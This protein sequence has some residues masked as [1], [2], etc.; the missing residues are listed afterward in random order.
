MLQIIV[1][2]VLW[3]NV[4]H[5]N[6]DNNDSALV[7]EEFDTHANILSTL[8]LLIMQVTIICNWFIKNFHSS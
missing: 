1:F 8:N 7:R 2:T 3:K 4:V 6:D 5:I